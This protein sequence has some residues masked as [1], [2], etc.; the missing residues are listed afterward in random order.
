MREREREREREKSERESRERERVV[1]VLVAE[2]RS[3]I[4]KF[5]LLVYGDFV[6]LC[7]F[8]RNL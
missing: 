5:S 2:F 6:E 3:H 1:V 8:L 7:A 4:W